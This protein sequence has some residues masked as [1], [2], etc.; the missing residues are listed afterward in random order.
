MILQS[1]RIEIKITKDNV[2]RVTFFIVLSISAKSVQFYIAKNVIVIV[3]HHHHAS[4]ASK[5]IRWKM[6]NVFLYPNKIFL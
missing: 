4:S 2:N 1:I 5:D 3:I 6:E